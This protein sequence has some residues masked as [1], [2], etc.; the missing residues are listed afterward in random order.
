MGNSHGKES[1]PSDNA[2][3]GRRRSVA[4]YPSHLNADQD[5]DRRNRVSRGDLSLLGLPGPSG[6]RDRNRNREDAPF[7]HKETRAEREARKLERERAI[8]LQER[9]YSIKEE[10]VDGGY[11]VTLGTYTGPED[12][13]KQ[14]VRQLQLERKLAPFWRG[15]N[16]WSENWT[17]HQLIAAARGL[18]IPAADE[19]PDPDLVP[20]PPP[21]QNDGSQ[22]LHSLTVP[23]GPRTLSAASDRSGSGAQSPSTSAAPAKMSPL[24]AGGRAKAIAA[25]LSYGSRNGSSSELIPKEVK[26]PHDPFVNGQPLEVYLYKNA[27]ECP[28]CFLSYPPYL[29]KTRCCDQPICS[30]CFVQIKRSDPHIPEHH[31]DGQAR[32]PNEGLGPDDP[33]E[34]LISEP[35]ACPYCQQ[36]EFGVTYDPPPFRRG[37]GYSGSMSSL[38][39]SPAMSSQ[40]SLHSGTPNSPNVPGRRR[41]HSLS[42]TAPNV[43]ATDRVRPDWASKLAAAR[44]HQARRSAAA[45]ALH[46][47]AFLMG[48][49]EQR[50]ILRPGRFG[51]RNAGRDQRSDGP[52]EARSIQADEAAS[53]STEISGQVQPRGGRGSRRHRVEDLEDMMFMEAVRLSLASEEERKRKEEK[54]MRKE[55]R[56]REK[57]EK[58]AAK[59]QGTHPY[60]GSGGGSSSS[61]SLPGFGRRRG[62]STTSNL[63]ME[64][65]VQGASNV[66]MSD[67]SSPT[68]EN[69][70]P[71]KSEDNI[72]GS[73]GKGVDRGPSPDQSTTAG[74]GSSVGGSLPVPSAGRSGSHLR[75]ISNASSVGSS[76]ADSPSGSTPGLQALDPRASGTS[77]AGA[78]DDGDRD[79]NSE[80]MFNF[81]S[82]AEIVGVNIE[83]GSVRRQDESGNTATM[84]TSGPLPQVVED[85][86]EE[87]EAEHVEESKTAEPATTEATIATESQKGREGEADEDIT[88]D[89]NMGHPSITERTTGNATH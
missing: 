68:T 83:D 74:E 42:A 7:E 28:I 22:N 20:R 23:M 16:D 5:G 85:E 6:S 55:S 72:L 29:N 58:K 21:P 64:A 27:S 38:V 89:K 10:H 77:I 34:M 3:A 79:A 19:T 11:L 26:L 52:G 61:L 46:T 36:P 18:P 2:Y 81:H 65:T 54:A 71:S 45:T 76:G 75:Q 84:P 14:V 86:K 25:A 51:R 73:K 63:R 15:L 9:E 88:A 78:S 67:A 62:N 33:P 12:F 13:N 66:P 37:L 82:L 44:A 41:G 30:E 8:R 60:G 59:K 69:N 70:D 39:S 1:G 49:N 50:S 35:A 24:K 31:P 17:E 48:D 40:S 80:P 87:A 47:A 32:D 43:V 56:K 53:G 57:E 4:G